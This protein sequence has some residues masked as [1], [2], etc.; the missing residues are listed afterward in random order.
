MNGFVI[1]GFAVYTAVIINANIMVLLI[2]KAW[3][4]FLYATI[5]TFLAFYL[6]LNFLMSKWYS[7]P[8]LPENIYYGIDARIFHNYNILNLLIIIFGW[9]M[10]LELA[11]ANY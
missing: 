1:T 9:T 6:F 8:V 11:Y 7:F 2:A 4:I 3:S 5:I 10:L